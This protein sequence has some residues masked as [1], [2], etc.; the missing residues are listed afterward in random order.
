MKTI[1]TISTVFLLF[2][3]FQIFATSYTFNGTGDWDDPSLWTP[4][5]PGLEIASGDEVIL[6][7]DCTTNEFSVT[8]MGLLTING[9]LTIDGPFIF[10]NGDEGHVVVNGNLTVNHIMYNQGLITVENDLVVNHIL[11]N[12][13]DIVNNGTFYSD[14]QPF[15]S[16][17]SIINSGTFIDEAGF[18]EQG[19][20]D[21]IGV[22]E[23]N[24]DHMNDDFI[25]NGCQL[26]PAGTGS[27]GDYT[28]FSNL[29]GNTI[30]KL[31]IAGTGGAG[32]DH[33]KIIGLNQ[34]FA[35]NLSLEVHLESGFEPEAGDSFEILSA[36]N[37]IVGD[38]ADPY[39]SLPSLTPGL[40]WM[41]VNDGNSMTLHVESTVA[42]EFCPIE[43]SENKGD[44]L[45][46][47][48]SYTEI[49]HDYY[50]I[51]HSSHT[52]SWSTIGK[53]Y[54]AGQSYATRYYDYKHREVNSGDNYYRI[55]AVD[56]A[57][58][59]QISTI[60][61]IYLDKAPEIRVWPTVFGRDEPISINVNE[62]PEEQYEFCLL[63]AS[64]K[65]IYKD[66]RFLPSNSVLKI[67]KTLSSGAY[68]LRIENDSHIIN[69][70][71]FIH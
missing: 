62:L 56:N 7:G 71:L 44:V 68:F 23:G 64:G 24:A 45:I 6:D 60:Q 22:W 51:E 27:I 30:L 52:N 4:S 36:N 9:S 69:H 67:N 13:E 38:V 11:I 54:G 55:V 70:R 25:G 5:Y 20:T 2:F 31:E 17:G 1:S 12:F 39:N 42:V 61:H 57:G 40:I 15:N 43:L 21:H 35:D 10:L 26:S 66:N 8:I 50:R 53:V 16:S 37:G 48:C 3:S 19:F 47:W 34:I 29:T 28:F 18:F 65:I 32:I 14:G 49:D 41:Y 33:D 63:D 58:F 59:E 46:E